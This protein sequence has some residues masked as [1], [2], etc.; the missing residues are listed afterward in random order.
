MKKYR[1]YALEGLFKWLP[2]VMRIDEHYDITIY[3]TETNTWEPAPD[4]ISFPDMCI[5]KIEADLITE[6]QANEIIK[7]TIAIREENLKKSNPEK[8]HPVVQISPDKVSV[9]KVRPE[10]VKQYLEISADTKT[11]AQQGD[12]Y[13]LT[14]EQEWD[15]ETADHTK[16]IA[17]KINTRLE[18]ITDCLSLSRFTNHNPY[19]M[20][21]NRQLTPEELEKV[22]HYKRV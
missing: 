13:L 10:R 19:W 20:I 7:Q 18:T 22:K 5:G 6:E 16:I 17:C 4:H 21:P 14:N 3:N 12:S 2:R 11:F 1:Y 9:T 8:K 15:Y